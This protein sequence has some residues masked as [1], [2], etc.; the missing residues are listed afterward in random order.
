MKGKDL[1][2][3]VTEFNTTVYNYFIDNFLNCGKLYRP[4]LVTCFWKKPWSK[5]ELKQLQGNPNYLH[6]LVLF[7]SNHVNTSTKLK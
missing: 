5:A 1:D 4:G 2:T 6:V 7:T 3:A